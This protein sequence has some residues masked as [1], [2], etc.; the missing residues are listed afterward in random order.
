MVPT[1]AEIS[2]RVCS[3][4]GEAFD[5]GTIR[6]PVTESWKL[7]DDFEP[8][9][10]KNITVG[11]S[12]AL[13]EIGEVLAAHITTY[14]HMV[15]ALGDSKT[16]GDLVNL[17]EREL[18]RARIIEKSLE[19]QGLGSFHY[20]RWQGQYF[21]RMESDFLDKLDLGVINTLGETAS[22]ILL[23]M[24]EEGFGLSIHA[25]DDAIN[26]GQAA[27]I[28]ISERNKAAKAASAQAV[29]A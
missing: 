14:S 15:V 22:I 2:A 20:F 26:I 19:L 12:L 27:D 10:W 11:V 6:R 28:I 7:W 18:V 25:L 16:V 9:S 5:R 23:S 3:I 29:S 24:I 13:S 21:E 4:L 1:R 17:L 8:N